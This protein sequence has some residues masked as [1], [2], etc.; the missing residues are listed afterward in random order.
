MPQ[1]RY[2]QPPEHCTGCA[3]CANVCPADTIRMR[4]NEDGFL[5]PQVNIEHC[6]NCGA[7]IKA[8]PAQPAHLE[9]LH[10]SAKQGTNPISYGGWHTNQDLHI[11]SSSGGIFS[12]LA[13][14]IFSK[15]GCVYGVVWRDKITAAFCKAEDMQELAPMRGS[16]YTQAVP[17]FV[18][19]EVKTEL[20]KNRYVLFVG[21]GCQVYALKRY[22][23]KPFARLLTVDIICAGVPSR[24]LLSSYVNYLEKKH[25][26]ELLHLNFR[27]KDGN[28]LNY[29]VQKIFIDGTKEA[30]FTSENQFMNLFLSN[31]LFNKCC[32]KCPHTGFPRQ[33]D[34]TLGDYWGVQYDNTKWPIK[35]GIASIIANSDKGKQTI[36]SLAQDASIELH[37]QPFSKLYEGQ[38]HS[39]NLQKRKKLPAI[40][41]KVLTALRTQS[42]EEIHETYYNHTYM[43]GLKIHRRSIL[44]KLAKLP[45]KIKNL[46][47]KRH[48]AL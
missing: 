6:I 4:L 24:N 16:K 40:R 36:E 27:Y 9:I 23:R 30:D 43:W 32:Y 34:I 38:P 44:A 33:G 37:N 29:K 42:L 28:W 12:A 48:S 25:G 10:S 45:S 31:Q 8:C 35:E 5:V 11:A 22:L 15:G 13:E 3:L 18:Y 19:R 26:K 47:K 39:Y 2:I 41:N 20:E 21:T 1:K 14:W 17:D 7:C 46:F